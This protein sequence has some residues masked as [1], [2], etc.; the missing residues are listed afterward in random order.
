ME[1]FFARNITDMYRP[2]MGYSPQAKHLATQCYNAS[3]KGSPRHPGLRSN[4]N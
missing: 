4:I 3:V 1:E 2:P